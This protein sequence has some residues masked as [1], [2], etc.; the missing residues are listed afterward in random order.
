MC[1]RFSLSVSPEALL[2]FIGLLAL[3]PLPPRFNIAPTQPVGTVRQGP[4]GREWHVVRWGLRP[5][6]WEPKA[7]LINARAEGI[8]DRPAFRSAARYRRCLVPADGFYEW[9]VEGG[10]RLPWFFRRRDGAP[11][12]LAGLWERRE[13]PEGPAESCTIVTVAANRGVAP[14]HDRMPLV[15]LPVAWDRWLDP[16]VRDPALLEPL[17]V[18]PADDL[19]EAVPVSPRVNDVRNDGPEC[20]AAREP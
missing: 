6:G 10:R 8:F 12:A 16:A 9:R 17:L 20:H 4:G 7:P 15:L 19:L 5:P 3:P 2:E 11:V 1:G 18:P 13:D 14:F